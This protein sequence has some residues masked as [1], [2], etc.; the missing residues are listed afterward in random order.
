[1]REEIGIQLRLRRQ[2]T[3]EGDRRDRLSG[4]CDAKLSGKV[5]ADPLRGRG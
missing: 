1:M 4:C 5:P 2:H 3:I